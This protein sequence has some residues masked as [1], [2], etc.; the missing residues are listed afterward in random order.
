MP[1]ENY[2]PSDPQKPICYECVHRRQ[3]PGN[4]HSE[5]KNYR[6]KLTANPHGV[7]HGWFTWPFDFDPLWLI[8]C[9]GF[10][11]RDDAQKTEAENPAAQTA[12]LGHGNSDEHRPAAEAGPTSG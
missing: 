3:L 8:S 4:S 12:A 6:A 7:N 9:N 1:I 5:C 2:T 11:R 10:Q